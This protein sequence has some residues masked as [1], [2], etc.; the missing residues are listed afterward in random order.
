MFNNRMS[1]NLIKTQLNFAADF[2]QKNG[3][4]TK[5]IRQISSSMFLKLFKKLERSISF[6][7]FKTL[8]IM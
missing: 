1:L 2:L 3:N 4:K 6:I 5:D 7:R 8:N